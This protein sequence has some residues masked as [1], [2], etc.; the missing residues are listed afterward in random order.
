MQRH[1]NSFVSPSPQ[2]LTDNS[3][4]KNK[5]NKLNSSG[6]SSPICLQLS[7][8]P[9]LRNGPDNGK[10]TAQQRLQMNEI[11]ILDQQLFEEGRSPIQ[12]EPVKTVASLNSENLIETK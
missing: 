3:R 2:S 1:S 9:G 11:D 7:Q 4:F 8:S 5:I 6:K 12:I 10:F